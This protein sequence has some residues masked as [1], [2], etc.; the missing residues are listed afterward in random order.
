MTAPVPR[1]MLAVNMLICG[2]LTFKVWASFASPE[3]LFGEDA[4][5]VGATA[6]MRELGG[7]NLAMLVLSVAAFARPRELLPAVFLLGL[8]RETTDMI[9]VIVNAGV[10]AGSLA[11]AASFL[12]FIVAYLSALPRMAASNPSVRREAAPQGR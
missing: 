6:G 4:W 12:V 10:S 9:L 5:G 7:R 2:I 1:W 11:Q 8:V 3:S